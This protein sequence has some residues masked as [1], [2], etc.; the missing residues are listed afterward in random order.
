MT[1]KAIGLA[2]YFDHARLDEASSVF[3]AFVV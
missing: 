3:E 1:D 2:G